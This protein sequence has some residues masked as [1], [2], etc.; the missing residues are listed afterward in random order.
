M[1]FTSLQK[2]LGFLQREPGWQTHHQLQ[3]ILTHWS[4]IVGFA[5]AAQTRP[6]AIQRQVLHVA[7]SSPV[8]AQNLAF[9]R[10]HILDKLNR[11]LAD[12]PLAEIR[13]ST[14]QW[15]RSSH[16]SG[17]RPKSDPLWTQHPSRVPPFSS[18]QSFYPQR[19]EA[20]DPKTAFNDWA[21]AIKLRT[22]SLPRCPSCQCPTPAGELERWSVCA[23]CAAQTWSKRT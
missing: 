1:T 10:R 22:Q 8:W 11:Y 20:K 16:L 15:H 7:T 14:N 6:V 19:G 18:Q 9:E 23:L 13:F 5:V 4:E 17:D 12:Q 21:T 2:A 3:H